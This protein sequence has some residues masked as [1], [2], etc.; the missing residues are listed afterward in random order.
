MIAKRAEEKKQVTMPVIAE[1]AFTKAG[2]R[3]L[4]GKEGEEVC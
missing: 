1:G 2:R 4:I 3:E